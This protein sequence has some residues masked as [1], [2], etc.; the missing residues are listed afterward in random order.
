MRWDIKNSLEQSPVNADVS[1]PIFK[2]ALLHL[3]GNKT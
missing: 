1:D 3:L 2:I